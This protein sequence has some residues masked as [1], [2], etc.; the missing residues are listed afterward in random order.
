MLNEVPVPAL[1]IPI[2]TAA[3]EAPET[4]DLI[5][6]PALAAA[7]PERETSNIV[8]VVKPVAEEAKLIPLPVVRPFTF[9][10]KALPELLVAQSHWMGFAPLAIVAPAVAAVT[11]ERA[12][13][14]PLVND[15]HEPPLWPWKSVP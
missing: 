10:L 3:L 15:T 8:P 12:G 5:S 2:G 9:M 4:V 14:E 11:A 1:L 7:F 13:L 6:V